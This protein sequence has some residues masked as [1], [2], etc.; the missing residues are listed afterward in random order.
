[1]YRTWDAYSSA[2]EA[3]QRASFLY[4]QAQDKRGEA[5]CYFEQGRV[6]S[7]TGDL[8]SALRAY[9]KALLLYGQIQ[10]QLGAANCYLMQEHVYLKTGNTHSALEAFQQ[11]LS[12]YQQVKNKLGEANCYHSQRESYFLAKDYLSALEAYQ[13]ALPLYQQL[14]R[15][16]G[17]AT[18]YYTQGRAYFHLGDAHSALEAYQKALPLYQQIKDKQG[19][20]KCYHSQGRVY[21]HLGDNQAAL[22]KYHEALALFDKINDPLSRAWTYHQIGQLQQKESNFADALQA[23]Q[24]A[25][26]DVESIRSKAGATTLKTE[27]L[28]DKIVM[29]DKMLSVVMELRDDA[30]SLIN[31]KLGQ[32]YSQIAFAYA[33]KAR[34][35][36]FLDQLEERKLIETEKPSPTLVALLNQ[37]D[38]LEARITNLNNRLVKARIDSEEDTE[39]M[40]QLEVEM[41]QAKTALAQTEQDIRIADPRYADIVYPQP[42]TAAEVQRDLLDAHTALLE[43]FVGEEQTYIF[44]L[45]QNDCKAIPILHKRSELREKVMQYL[46]SLWALQDSEEG[47]SEYRD[48]HYL[49]ADYAISYAPSASALLS[50]LKEANRKGKS[51]KSLKDLLAFG[52]AIYSKPQNAAEAPNKNESAPVIAQAEQSDQNRA[53]SANPLTHQN[54]TYWYTSQGAKLPP[55]PY[56]GV[57]V[58]A[59][60]ELFKDLPSVHISSRLGGE[61]TEENAK[62][63]C[64]VKADILHFGVHG[65]LDDAYPMYS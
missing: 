49:L 18:C 25:I 50:V 21:F 41:Q 52:D 38:G 16:L 6:Y 26:R 14:R 54:L 31:P 1:V 10:H 22:A 58:E 19:E 11:A 65:L 30:V 37:R 20:A 8:H 27:F 23:Y 64:A 48:A 34:A 4:Q 36:A 32:S 63:Q 62:S 3:Y 60:E 47:V 24:A 28:A 61:A 13:K 40:A 43:Y 5:H 57:A 39:E 51:T 46:Q 55:L 56:T 9:Q 45:T 53:T 17:E 12:L 42:I 29:Y 15:K 7:Y 59:L 35:R 2:L 33:E 44:V